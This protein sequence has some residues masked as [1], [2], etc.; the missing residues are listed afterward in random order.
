MNSQACSYQVIWLTSRAIKSGRPDS[1]SKASPLSPA[2]SS[3]ICNARHSF[4][5]AR[6]CDFSRPRDLKSPHTRFAR[7]LAAEYFVHQLGTGG[8][9]GAELAAVDQFGSTNLLV[10]GDPGDLLYGHSA[11]GHD[12]HERVP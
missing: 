6:V 2:V 1:V 11:C 5:P 3:G 7:T 8:D 12:A 10:T 4:L 9:D